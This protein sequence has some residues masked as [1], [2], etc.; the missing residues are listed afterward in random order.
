MQENSGL[1]RPKEESLE[2]LENVLEDN[3]TISEAA[4][5]DERANDN[6]IHPESHP[7]HNENLG[8]NNKEEDSNA[9]NNLINESP[10]TNYSGSYHETDQQKIEHEDENCLDSEESF[11]LDEDLEDLLADSDNKMVGEAELI[12]DKDRIT[13]VTPE[14]SVLK[15]EKGPILWEEKISNLIKEKLKKSEANKKIKRKYKTFDMS[16]VQIRQGDKIVSLNDLDSLL[17]YL[18]LKKGNVFKCKECAYTHQQRSILKYHAE[19][20]IKQL[21]IVCSICRHPCP[22]RQALRVHNKVKHKH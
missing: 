10:T 8:E 12:G 5:D 13:R 22:T 4:M 6:T 17:E 19:T 21:S 16:N 15:S 11:D 3:S 1:V 9:T 20:H 18:V 7:E 2:V 14:E